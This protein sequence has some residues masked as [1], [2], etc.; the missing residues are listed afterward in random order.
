M[1]STIIYIV[2]LVLGTA[3]YAYYLNKV[4][5]NKR[6]QKEETKK[7]KR[8]FWLMVVFGALIVVSGELLMWKWLSPYITNEFALYFLYTLIEIF[9]IMVVSLL[10]KCIVNKRLSDCDDGK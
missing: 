7:G 9:Y 6:M 2:L 5:L 3:G 10:V 4:I 8:D 1:W